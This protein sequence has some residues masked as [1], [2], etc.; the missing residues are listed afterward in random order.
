MPAD[1]PRFPAPG[2]PVYRTGPGVPLP[3]DPPRAPRPGGP[4]RS[5][6]PAGPPRSR[7]TLALV[8][9]VLLA[10]GV[11]AGVAVYVLGSS[12]ST[13]SSAAASQTGT[14]TQAAGPSPA[15][16]PASSGPASSPAAVSEQ[17]AATDL[18]GL[19]AQSVQDRS[20][21][22]AA[23]ADVSDCGP[24]LSQD[25]QTF[26]NAAASRQQLLSQLADLPGSST[27]PAVLLQD[28]TGAWQASE[29]ADQDLGSWAQDE[30]SEGC[31]QN[32][33]ADPNYQAATT[34]DNQATADKKAFVSQWNPIATQYGLTTYQ[35]NQL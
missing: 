16:P 5:P 20:A 28:L 22:V 21:I 11:A 1:P 33:Q 8:L 14:A 3:A 4:P 34:P 32:D 29:A 17:Q 6:R 15:S 13:A 26:Q 12:H 27:L 18:A 19:L 7:R 35:W 30:V 10:A 25:P 31:T 2:G 24:T 9:T 23:A